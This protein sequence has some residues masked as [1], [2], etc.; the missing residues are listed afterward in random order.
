MSE[1]VRMLLGE[2]FLLPEVPRQHRRRPVRRG[3]TGWRARSWRTGDLRWLGA[4]LAGL[5]AA[6]MLGLLALAIG[7]LLR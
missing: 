6:L 4:I 7:Y 2:V 1:A 5:S 3:S